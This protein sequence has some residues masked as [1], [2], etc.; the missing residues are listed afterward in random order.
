MKN[1]LAYGDRSAKGD[2]G[3]AMNSDTQTQTAHVQVTIPPA[4]VA[5]VGRQAF[6]ASHETRGNTLI[7]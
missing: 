3:Q 7:E 1:G 5:E 6:P 2:V 4:V